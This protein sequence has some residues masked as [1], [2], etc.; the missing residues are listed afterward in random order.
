MKTSWPSLI[1]C[2]KERKKEIKRAQ[3][4]RKKLGGRESPLGAFSQH[5]N[6]FGRVN[7]VVEIN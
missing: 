1:K 7:Q 6:L 3:K 4:R 5:P 2:Q